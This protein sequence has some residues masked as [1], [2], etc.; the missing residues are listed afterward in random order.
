MNDLGGFV[1]ERADGA[2]LTLPFRRISVLEV[3]DRDRFRQIK[4]FRYVDPDAVFEREYYYR[5]VSF[6]LDGYV[7][8]PSNIVMAIHETTAQETHAPLSPP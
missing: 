5:V 6:T 3:S 2:D 4:A 7:S 8:A 1:I